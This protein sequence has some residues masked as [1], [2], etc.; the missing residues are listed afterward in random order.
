MPVITT[1]P[2]WLTD[3]EQRAWRAYLAGSRLLAHHLERELQRFGLSMSDYE[4]MVHL[5]ESAD[6]RLRMSS[7][8]KAT[9][10]EKS[11]LSHPIPRIE[12]DGLVARES[13]P[14][15][16]RGQFAVLTEQ[17]W[18]T[19]QRVAPFHVAEVRDRLFDLLTPEQVEALTEIFEP[20]GD[21][22]RATP[23]CVAAEAEA[24]L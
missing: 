18:E 8:A 5:S 12:R 20:V 22:L 4:I 6:R 15:D 13:C 19:I 23:Q 2:R 24:D 17:G 3:S 10:L 9:L 1:E 16:R 7:L 14:G 11:R 21:R